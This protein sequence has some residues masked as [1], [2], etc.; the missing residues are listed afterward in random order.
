MMNFLEEQASS[1]T[2]F[3]AD[4]V[5]KYTAELPPFK[6]KSRFRVPRN[7]VAEDQQMI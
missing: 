3:I 1:S 5:A 2:K 6:K 4:M 7:P